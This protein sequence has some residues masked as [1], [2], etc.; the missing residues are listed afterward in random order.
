MK[1]IF[2]LMLA[3]IMVLSLSV[4]AFAAEG[5]TQTISVAGSDTHTYNVYQIFIGKI[6]GGKMIDIT[7]GA[8]LKAGT[9]LNEAL[10][11]LEALPDDAT[12][13]E[14]LNAV[15]PYVNMDAPHKVV[16]KD[17]PAQVA[18]GY[19]LMKDMGTVADGETYSL[20]ILKVA[21]NVEINTK[22][23]NV[24]SVKKVDDVNDSDN[25]TQMN[26]DSADYDIGD[27]VP[28]TLTATLPA[29]YAEFQDY[30]YLAFHDTLAPGLTFNNDVTV[31]IDGTPITS[32]YTVVTEGLHQG[33]S[34]EVRFPNLKSISAAA[35]G[36][37]VTV[38]YTAKLEGEAVVLG[39]PGNE[40]TMYVQYSNDPNY[41][42]DGESTPDT[43]KDPDNPPPTG[44]T[45]EDKVI[46][47]T[48]AVSVDKITKNPQ[49]DSGKDADHTGTDSDGDKEYIALS[50]AGFTLYKW[51][52]DVVG[53][54]KWVK[55]G[56]EITGL[57]TFSWSGL[58]D[59]K[60]KLVETTVPPGYNSIDPV[61][62]T[63]SA[64]HTL[65]DD[66]PPL[67]TLNGGDTF[68]GDVDTGV[69]TTPIENK[70]GVVLPGTGGIGTTI[71]YLAGGILVLAAIV[72]LVT[73]KRMASAE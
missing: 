37:I 65:E 58:D 22:R 48:Y 32:G 13:T 54:D 4:T 8:N 51:D 11:V 10:A 12:D 69:L 5:E 44:N 21:N 61:E 66:N 41:V 36:K 53:D 67:V 2:A 18:P 16:T 52:A 30:F 62:F 23:Q 46:V 9:D 40:N 38:K 45:P 26:K 35:A 31:S 7:E 49:Y 24:I 1:R 14:I 55:I 6:S 70:P 59:G 19:Y 43:P 34:F 47:F 17:N 68:T 15:L 3:L 56:D 39:N 60:Y 29:N 25:T 27:N 20:H 63:I 33:C 57:T 42:W 64:V 28:F 72:M 71:F 50:G 73:K